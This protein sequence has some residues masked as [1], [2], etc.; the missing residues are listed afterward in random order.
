MRV[1]RKS[2]FNKQFQEKVA[3]LEALISAVVQVFVESRLVHELFYL[4]VQSILTFLISNVIPLL[5]VSPFFIMFW[6]SHNSF[7]TLFTLP[8]AVIHVV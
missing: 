4:L 7:R 2:A 8:V 5:I 6:F 1:P 3:F